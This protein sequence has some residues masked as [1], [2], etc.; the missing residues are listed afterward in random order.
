MPSAQVQPQGER[1]ITPQLY[2]TF[3]LDRAALQPLLAAAPERF[4]VAA[5]DNST[6]LLLPLPDGSMGRFRLYESPVMA[7]LLQDKYPEIRCYTGRGLDDPTAQLKCDLSPWGFHAQILS[8]RHSPVFIDP[9]QTGDQDH[10]VVYF[11]KDYALPAEEAPFTCGVDVQTD[12]ALHIGQ[13]PDYQGDCQLRRYRLAL[14]CTGEYATFH[15]GTKPLV[16]AAMNTS[17]NRV[18]G[19]YENEFAVTMQIVNNNNLLIYLNGTTDP[20]TND[21]GGA[22]L[23][24]NVATC[25]SVIGAANYDI[26]H[27]F[28]TGGGGVAGLG[29]VC[30][31]IKA[32]GVTGGGSPIGDP[33]DIDYV[34]HEIGHQFG[35]NHTQNNGCNRVGSASMEPGSASTIM[36]YAGICSPNVQPNSDAYFHAINIQEMA[37]FLTAGGNVCPIKINIGNNSPTVTGGADRTIPKGTPFALTAT[38]TDL[39]GDTLSYCWEQMDAEFATMPPVASSATGPLFRSFLPTT[40]PTRYFPRLSDLVSNI[41]DDW[42]ELP[43]V[44]RNMKFRV[45]ARDNNHNG[46]CTGEDNVVISVAAS[47]GPFVVT[48]PNTNVTWLVG[49][50]QTVTWDV[51]NTQL[52]PVNCLNVRLLLSTDGGYTYSVVLANSTSNTGSATVTVP[53]NL[54]A[55]CRVK[56][57]AV[58]NVFFDISNQNFSIQ[59]PPTPTFLLTS[60]TNDLQI[61]AGTNAVLTVTTASVAGF[62][63]PVQLTVSGAPVGANVQISQNPVAVGNPAIVTISGLTPAMAGTYSLT[64]QGSAASIQ[65]SISLP[66]SVLPGAPVGPAVANS[67]LDGALAVATSAVLTWSNVPYSQTYF[68]EIATNPAFTAGSVVSSQ[69]TTNDSLSNILLQPGTVYYWHIR[70]DNDCGP[71][72]FSAVYA[73]E[74]GKSV[75]NQIFTSVDVPVTID[76]ATLGT[77]YSSLQVPSGQQ[78]GD[79]NVSVMIDHSWVGDLEASLTSPSGQNFL[80]FS[81][82]GVPGNG[83]G[84]SGDNLSVVF[85]DA[86]AL[87]AADLENTC[88]GSAPAIGGTFQPVQPLSVLNGQVAQGDWQLSIEDYYEEDGG[89]LTAWSLAF[90]F[91]DTLLP[92]SLLINKLLTLGAGSPATVTGAFLKMKTSGLTSQ[93]RFVV[94]TPPQQGTLKLNGAALV[95]GSQFTQAD[96]DAGAVTYLH[97][98]NAATTDQVTFDAFDTNNSAWVHQGIFKIAIVQNNLVAQAAQTQTLLCHDD[99]NGQITVSATGLNGQYQYSLNGGAP[100]ASNVFGSLGSGT[101]TVIVSGQYGFTVSTVP[102]TISNPAALQVNTS[103]VND[104]LTITG[105]GGTGTLLY[106]LDGQNFGPNTAFPDLTNGVYTVTVRDANGCTATDQA[107]VAVNALLAI[108]QIQSPVL[109]FGGHEGVIVVQTGGGQPPFSYTLNGGMV[110][111]SNVFPNLSAGAYIVK[112]VDIQGFIAFT[113]TVLLNSPTPLVLTADATQNVI[114]ASATGGTGAFQY[115]LD[116]LSFQS[117]NVFASLANGSYSVTA[118]DANGCTATAT[119]TINVAALAG[120]AALNSPLPCSGAQTATLLVTSAGGIAPYEY[121]SNNG[122]FQSSNLFTGL[123]AGFFTIT[124]R[125]AAGTELSLPPVS[126][127]QLMPVE[128]DVVVVGNDATLSVSGGGGEPYTYTLNGLA[129]APLTN[130]ANGTYS[131]VATDG[132][133]GCTGQMTFT[134]NYIPVSATLSVEDI[135]PCDEL[136]DLTVSALGGV[137]PYQYALDNSPNRTDSI[138]ENVADGVHTVYVLDAQGEIFSL[139]IDFTIAQS[140]TLST[141]VAGDSIVSVASDGLAPYEYSLDGINYQN[142]PVFGSLPGGTYVVTVRDANGCTAAVENILIISGLVEPGLVWG[143][144]ILPNP[145][146]GLF[147]LHFQSALTSTLQLEVV[148]IAGQ[149]LKTWTLEPTNTQFSTPLDLLGFPAGTYVLRLTDG[150]NWGAARLQVLR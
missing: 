113:G 128:P 130:L 81:Q 62:A 52:A 3:A 116:G 66:L 139:P 98:G 61:C 29:V 89:A 109:C 114:T 63:S 106:S 47:A 41:N 24:E 147:Q 35:G 129:N 142:S 102:V 2:R 27:V 45:T 51:A 101:Y 39:N 82:P 55:T 122:A 132:S 6:V 31:D 10:Y 104:D 73:F 71:G 97:D 120:S 42:E 80:L 46:G 60:T 57:E 68:I 34:A 4:T 8:A 84:C 7:P 90:C 96:L 49:S 91:S 83:F 107:I 145:S 137:A 25:D 74:T 99:N 9:F 37:G 100:Q 108:A 111:L 12:A 138:F 56:V 141:T 77:I 17:M 149:Q 127:T 32:W 133:S 123:G 119:A 14:A 144:S 20:Y 70:A 53:N 59:L 67:P 124:I 79:V 121:R 13:M 22:M 105:S 26:G 148:D 43:G 23:D 103:V 76:G 18:N 75:C 65:Q 54:S 38:G 21:D 88:N 72:S 136:V 11:K 86:A 95:L 135:E 69:T 30:S 93:G 58:G 126:I 87:L 85:D 118:R 94:L 28:S 44:G 115:S 125:D 1:R 112:V 40:A 64:V 131:L 50:A 110:Q 5:A 117:S 78:I 48:A 150:K 33:F 15:G 16:L 19:V 146:A 143:L 134:I 140:V 92:G 36:G